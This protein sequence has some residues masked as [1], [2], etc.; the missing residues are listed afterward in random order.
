M[1]NAW[2][3]AF[4]VQYSDPEDTAGGFEK[5]ILNNNSRPIKIKVNRTLWPPLRICKKL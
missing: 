5:D 4:I 3:T 1:K 2:D